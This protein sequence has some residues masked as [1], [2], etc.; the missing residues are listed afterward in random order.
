ML[1]DD[2]RKEMIDEAIRD[3]FAVN[4]FRLISECDL[5]YD[6]FDYRSEGYRE[7]LAEKSYEMAEHL[8]FSRDAL[9]LGRQQERQEKAR[10]RPLT[11]KELDALYGL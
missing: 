10:G 8:M 7:R 4:A 2:E 1:T 3:A 9:A 5:K 11:E 6:T